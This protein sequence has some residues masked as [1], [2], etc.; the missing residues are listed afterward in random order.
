MNLEWQHKSR[1]QN[2]F[3]FSYVCDRFQLLWNLIII[4]SL[5]LHVKKI[6]M[7]ILCLFMQFYDVKIHFDYVSES[8]ITKVSLESFIV[9]EYI[10]NLSTVWRLN[11]HKILQF[12]K[13]IL[14]I[15]TWQ[16]KIKRE[17][18]L[19]EAR[20]KTMKKNKKTNTI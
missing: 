11:W 18:K 13:Q 20:K 5:K 15:Q 14:K 10:N 16:T 2:M 17:A 1:E 3:L 4:F 19:I 12:E 8:E 7:R 6:V 9:D